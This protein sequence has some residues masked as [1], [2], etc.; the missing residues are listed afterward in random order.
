MDPLLSDA[1]FGYAMMLVRL[2]RYHEARDRLTD[3]MKAHPD[4]P[5]FSHALARLLA[6]APDDRV[7]DGRRAKILVDALF[8]AQQSI[9]LGETIAMTLAELQQYEQAAAVQ[10]DMMAAAKQAGLSD[11]A[12]RRM[13]ENLRLYERRELR[14]ADRSLEWQVLQLMW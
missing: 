14:L 6:A 13:A 9:E 5:M 11:V 7:R 4:E 12:V 10:R 1:A 3:G 8:K 2:R